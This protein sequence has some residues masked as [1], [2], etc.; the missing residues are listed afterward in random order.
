MDA[1]VI[2][3]MKAIIAEPMP[4]SCEDRRHRIITLTTWLETCIAV[5]E[6]LQ[7]EGEGTDQ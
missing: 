6:R 4:N 1:S 3:R 2:T 5:I 7:A